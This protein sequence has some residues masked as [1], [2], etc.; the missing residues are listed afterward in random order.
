[1]R[2]NK[3]FT[4]ISYKKEEPEIHFHCPIHTNVRLKE[5]PGKGLWCPSGCGP[6]IPAIRTVYTH[7]PSAWFSRTKQTKEVN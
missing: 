2:H 5:I 3:H 1:M 6:T 7:N 4:I